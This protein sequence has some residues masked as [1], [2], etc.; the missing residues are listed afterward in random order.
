MRTEANTAI[1]HLQCIC[2]KPG[3]LRGCR[4]VFIRLGPVSSMSLSYG[5][6][7]LTKSLTR[8]ETVTRTVAEA[9]SENVNFVCWGEMTIPLTAQ[10]PELVSQRQIPVLRCLFREEGD[11]CRGGHTRMK[12]AKAISSSTKSHKASDALCVLHVFFP[13]QTYSTFHTDKFNKG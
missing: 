11:C 6:L 13:N 1:S 12:R 3:D 5:I 10:P 9:G 7:R 8:C 4:D 2:E